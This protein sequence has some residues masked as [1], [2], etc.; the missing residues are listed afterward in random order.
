[1]TSKKIVRFNN[2][3][4]D[5][6]SDFLED[7]K[8]HVTETH[9]FA[10]SAAARYMG[11]SPRKLVDLSNEGSIPC[12]DVLNRRTYKREDLDRFMQSAKWT[13]HRMKNQKD[14]E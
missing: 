1:M 14:E 10:Q 9:W 4:T 11:I 7:P 13:K 5:D 12:Y 2:N 8:F 3:Q 6:F